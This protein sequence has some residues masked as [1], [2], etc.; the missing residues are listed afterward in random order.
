[1]STRTALPAPDRTSRSRRGFRVSR[2]NLHGVGHMIALRVAIIAAATAAVSFLMFAL[3]AISPF[4]PLAGFLGADLG[5]L[6]EDQREQMALVLGADRTWWEQWLSWVN[7]V[8][9]GDLGYSRVYR[10]PVLDVIAARLPWTLLLSGVGLAFMT[11]TALVLG[12]WAG[13]RPGG[14]I[15][16]V[17]LGVGAFVAATPSYIYAL[18]AVLVFAVTLRVIPAGGAAP[19]GAQ[20]SLAGAGPY[21]IAPAIVLGLSQISWPLLAV[22][23]ATVETLDDDAVDAAI[24]RGLPRRTVMLRHVA[25]MSLMPLITLVGARLGELVVGAVIVESVFSWPGLA[26]ATVQSAVQL[27]FPLLAAT[28]VAAT[29]VVMVGTLIADLLYLLIDPRVTDV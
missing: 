21:L 17:V 1:M 26:E 27:D 14:L 11:V 19:F 10:A 24:A 18:G 23:Q 9:R 13:R 25:P 5:S 28:T 15:D 20:P 29:L 4:D 8:L 7:G 6:T 16:R 12:V 2:D 3:A 22:R